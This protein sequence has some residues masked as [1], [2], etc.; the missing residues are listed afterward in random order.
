MNVILI[1]V[2][3]IIVAVVSS[4]IAVF[5]LFL[6]LGFPLAEYSWG[7]KYEGVLPY[8][9]RMISLPSAFLLLFFGFTFLIHSKVIILD[10]YLPTNIIVVVI[11]I[12]MGLNTLGNLA[13]KSRKERLVM[14]PLAAI[15]FIACLFV[16]ITS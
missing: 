16:V 12:F 8:K 13:S 10:F 7:G 15:T 4:G 11:T 2:A 3:A 14:A 1:Q 5:Q 6:F 9:M